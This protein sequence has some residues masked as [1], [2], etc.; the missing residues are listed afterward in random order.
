[1]I[2]PAAKDVRKSARRRVIVRVVVFQLLL[3]VVLAVA[4]GVWSWRAARALADAVTRIEATGEPMTVAAL[5]PDIP[6]PEKNGLVELK[7]AIAIIGAQTD[8]LGAFDKAID[9]PGYPLRD[10]ERAVILPF[11]AERVAARPLL[12]QAAAK[13]VCVSDRKLESPLLL[14]V[15]PEWAEYRFVARYLSTEAVARMSEGDHAE[16]VKRLSQIEFPAS[17]AGSH[18]SLV[19]HL[20]AAGCRAMQAGTLVAIA[21][22]LKIGNNPDE[23]NATELKKL[24]TSLLD[25]SHIAAEQLR[26]YQGERVMQVDALQTLGF[27]RGMTSKS[28]PGADGAS[29]PKP[30]A[31]K[32]YLW[33]PY[34]DASAFGCVEA[35]TEFLP[36]LASPDWPTARL[37]MNAWESKH[38]PADPPKTRVVSAMMATSLSRAAE[39]RYRLT[40]DRALAATALAVRWYRVDHEG[41]FPES[42]E[43]L[44]PK[45]LPMVPKDPMSAGGVIRYRAGDAPILWSA[46]SNGTDES[47]DETATPDRTGDWHRPDRV[48]RLTIQPRAVEPD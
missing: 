42:L 11:L 16:A 17:A 5:Q 1:M 45:Y 15:V 44:V 46:G 34:I 25:T 29:L 41:A 7:Q 37:A 20:V 48:V 24:I 10:D 6:P 26:A 35:T 19:A 40:T 31:L 9:S 30:S 32:R 33:Q 39:A 18:P 3:L 4:H 12:D 2:D 23:V 22:E 27:E 47:G 8:A 13:P 28:G 43:A 38:A 36:L 14:M 21:P